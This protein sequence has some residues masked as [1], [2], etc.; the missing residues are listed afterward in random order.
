M[1]DANITQ[2]A[3]DAMRNISAVAMLES[4]VGPLLNSTVQ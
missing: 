3:E 2:E 4:L 1:V